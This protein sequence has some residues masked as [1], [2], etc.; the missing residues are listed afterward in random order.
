MERIMGFGD[1]LFGSNP[2]TEQMQRYTPQQQ[3]A[4]NQ[5]LTQ[6]MGGMQGMQPWQQYNP[7]Q[8]NFA[9]IAEQARAGFR[10]QTL[11]S[12]AER[13]TS[14]LGGSR[15]SAFPQVL[16]QAATGLER[17]LAALNAQYGLQQQGY[18]LQGRGQDLSQRGQ[19]MG[20]YGNMINTGLQPQFDYRQTPGS[21]G[22]LGAMAPGIGAALGNMVLPG[23]GGLIGGGL[24]SMFG[25]H[26]QSG[27]VPQGMSNV[28]RQGMSNFTG[29]GNYGGPSMGMDTMGGIGRGG[30]SYVNQL[31]G[32][33]PLFS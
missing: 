25:G 12:I 6:G 31:M 13:F 5:L 3:S 11:P 27:Q 4:L 15:S 26:G 17:D 16:G 21:T 8:Y 20:M 18:N 23:L 1:F 24:G 28:F 2:T 22:F 29:F 14:H 10:E 33:M 7:Q 30:G 32:G 19:Q 9:P